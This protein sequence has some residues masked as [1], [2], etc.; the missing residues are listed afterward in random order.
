M[1]DAFAGSGQREGG[2]EEEASSDE[3]TLK[4]FP[5]D[6]ATRFLASRKWCADPEQV[7]ELA[8]ELLQLAERGHPVNELL[9]Q[10]VVMLPD[11]YRHKC[12]PKAL[13]SAAEAGIKAFGRVNTDKL[14][15]VRIQWRLPQSHAEPGAASGG[16]TTEAAR[17]ITDKIFLLLRIKNKYE[18]AW[19]HEVAHER[20]TLEVDAQYFDEVNSPS[21]QNSGTSVAFESRE[22]DAETRFVRVASTQARCLPQSSHLMLLLRLGSEGESPESLL[23][24]LREE[25][26][27][28]TLPEPLPAA[29]ERAAKRGAEAAADSSAAKRLCADSTGSS[30]PHASPGAAPAVP[31]AACMPKSYTSRNTTVSSPAEAM[32]ASF[33]LPHMAIRRSSQDATFLPK[34]ADKSGSLQPQELARAFSDDSLDLG[35]DQTPASSPWQA[36][37]LHTVGPEATMTAPVTPGTESQL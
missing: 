19:R 8:T 21:A 23:K 27:S 6:G 3:P 2:R 12:P 31:G 37:Q 25:L 14:K 17:K 5:L 34:W 20:H 18:G 10:A 11:K 4:D 22:G 29:H 24:Q 9:A 33:V 32:P 7:V 1:A 28:S 35:L 13:S 26:S 36:G 15:V 16:L 30:A